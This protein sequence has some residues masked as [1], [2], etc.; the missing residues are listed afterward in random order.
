MTMFLLAMYYISHSSFCQQTQVPQS[1]RVM[2]V[3]S[4][5]AFLQHYYY[6]YSTLLKE[7]PSRDQK[8]STKFPNV[9]FGGHCLYA[10]ES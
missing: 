10:H 4:R 7:L 5:V 3:L 1:Y 6:Y 8:H 9:L 2:D